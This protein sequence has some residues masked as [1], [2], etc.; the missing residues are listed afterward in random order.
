VGNRPRHPARPH[1]I[2]LVAIVAFRFST[3]AAHFLATCRISWTTRP[4]AFLLGLPSEGQS[5]SDSVYAK[6]GEQQQLCPLRL[7]CL[8]RRAKV[9]TSRFQARL[10]RNRGHRGSM[11]IL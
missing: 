7:T 11:K 6:P 3:V 8:R 1:A 10:A 5:T 2:L 4:M 9:A